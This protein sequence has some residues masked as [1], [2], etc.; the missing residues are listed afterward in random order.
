MLPS[1]L[2][3]TPVGDLVCVFDSGRIQDLKVEHSLTLVRQVQRTELRDYGG[4][5]YQL[6]FSLRSSVAIDDLRLEI[7]AELRDAHPHLSPDFGEHRVGAF[8]STKLGEITV[9]A[10]DAIL[11]EQKFGTKVLCE[12][13][14]P[15]CASWITFG[16][17]GFRSVPIVLPPDRPT[18]LRFA[19]SWSSC[20]E[21]TADMASIPA[22]NIYA[23]RG[24]FTEDLDHIVFDA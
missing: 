11:L 6:G 3:T 9:W 15:D 16:D 5:C 21:L 23:G 10:P 1:P 17:S 19:V 8:W 2:L 12:D 18:K 7:R 13:P 20:D 4:E 14:D 24:L 22:W